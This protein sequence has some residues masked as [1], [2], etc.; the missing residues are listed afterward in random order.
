MERLPARYRQHS[1][2]AEEIDSREPLI[3]AAGIVSFLFIPTSAWPEKL[4]QENP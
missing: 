2:M 4:L 3:I 1:M